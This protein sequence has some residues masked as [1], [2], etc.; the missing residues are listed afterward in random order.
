M[1]SCQKCQADNLVGAIFCRACGVKLEIDNIRPQTVDQAMPET[2]T[3]AKHVV[4]RVVT[5]AILLL[6]LGL[7]AGILLPASRPVLGEL[8]DQDKQVAGKNYGALFAPNPKP[9][10]VSFTS[11]QVTALI[12]DRLGLDKGVPASMSFSLVREKLEIF[13]LPSGLIR[14]VLKSRIMGK[15]P[16]YNAV[17]GTAE[18]S[19]AGVQ[20]K[21][22]A[23]QIGRITLPAF[24]QKPVIERIGPLF[25]GNQEIDFLR[26][27][28]T[29][30]DANDKRLDVTMKAVAPPKRAGRK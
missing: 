2:S 16:L 29:K 30:I 25:N 15:V 28:I 18:V 7:M 20:F 4:S 5:I 9:A 26:Q 17:N 23:A 3:H 24:L 27:N 12:N 11:D 21:V 13:I 10:P 1:I 8:N 19:D 22:T 14:V 6:V